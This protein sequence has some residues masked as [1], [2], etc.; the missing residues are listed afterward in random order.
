MILKEHCLDW[1]LNWKWCLE[2]WKFKSHFFLF[3][4]LA[5]LHMSEIQSP[6]TSES[7][8]WGARLDTPA[9]NTQVQL[10]PAKH[11]SSVVSGLCF[12]PSHHQDFEA[13]SQS[14]K[15][16]LLFAKV[17]VF[18]WILMSAVKQIVENIYNEGIKLL[19]NYHLWPY[20]PSHNLVPNICMINL[21][22]FQNR[23]LFIDTPNQAA[24]S[25]QYIVHCKAFGK[26]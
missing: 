5:C 7:P 11:T 6:R 26:T 10:L 21:T 23:S 22:I 9:V 13:C 16:F 17:R 2:F 14:T 1:R 24:E 8:L 12:L 19:G 25:E 20:T 4:F 15:G 18:F 3:H